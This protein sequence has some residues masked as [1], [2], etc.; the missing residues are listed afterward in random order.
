MRGVDGYSISVEC[1]IYGSSPHAWG[2][3]MESS[4]DSIRASVHPHMRGVDEDSVVK[5]LIHVGSSPHAWGRSQ[6]SEFRSV[7]QPVHPH[8]RG[9]DFPGSGDSG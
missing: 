4:F 5:L 6:V 7:R 9:V 3:S 1:N 8:M 2:R